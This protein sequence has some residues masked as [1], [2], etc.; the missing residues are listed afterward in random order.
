MTPDQ[1]LVFGTLIFALIFFAWGPW[2]YDLVSLLALLALTITGIIPWDHAFTGF[3]HP[4]VVTVAAV[5]IT[6]RGLHNSG[7]VEIIARWLSKAGNSPASQ[8]ASLTGSATIL[9]GFMN[10]VGALALLMPVGIRMA[11]K[12]GISPSILLMPLAFGGHLGG[13]L[14]LIGTPSNIIISTFRAENVGEPFRMF[15]FTPVGAGVA[16]AG[17]HLHLPDRLEAHPAEEASL[18]QREL[19]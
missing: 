4:A 16:L 8:V 12:S 6:S 19:V 18:I 14:T 7:I 15:D 13:L 2:R 9:S 11:L 1:A 5:L 10:N 17:V 3:G